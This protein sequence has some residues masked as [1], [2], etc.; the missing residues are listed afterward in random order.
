[1]KNFFFIILFIL[2]IISCTSQQ[3]DKKSDIV[4][5]NHEK[6][7][8]KPKVENQK[9]R[10]RNTDFIEDGAYNVVDFYK[11]RFTNIDTN[12]VD[13]IFE[14]NYILFFS[15]IDSIEY[16]STLE[17]YYQD[18]NIPKIEMNILEVARHEEK[19]L[20]R[21]TLISFH[22]S[23]FYINTKDSITIIP[24]KPYGNTYGYE[25]SLTYKGF[26]PELSLFVFWMDGFGGGSFYT[27]NLNS[28]ETKKLFG[29][30]KY[31]RDTSMLLLS[32]YDIE[33]DSYTNG[34]EIYKVNNNKYESIFKYSPQDWGPEGMVWKN[35]ST[36][37]FMRMTWDKERL[38]NKRYL[39][40]VKLRKIKNR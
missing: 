4:V 2:I 17:N 5:V 30:P 15:S 14:K 22:D 18:L 40:S 31:S 35:D 8:L 3:E 13:T 16:F 38:R 25:A 29:Y 21:D 11:H 19:V 36:L 1:M 34:F 9:I 12:I 27:Y 37:Y 39:Q 20:K 28:N 33:F 7:E 26:I 32:Y 10:K 6:D 24:R 23:C